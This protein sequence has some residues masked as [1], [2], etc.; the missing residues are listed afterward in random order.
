MQILQGYW[1]NVGINVDIKVV[2]TAVYFGLIFAR[3]KDATGQ[4]V[5]S[6]WPWGP[7]GPFPSF[8]NNVYHSANMFTS[9]GVHTTGNDPKADQ[10][11]QDAVHEPDETK[12]KQKWTDLMKYGYN[13]MWINMPIVEYPSYLVAGPNV[14]NFTRWAYTI[15]Q[16][17]YVGITHASK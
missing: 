5:G 14:G 6:I 3:A 8:F 9:V 1:K 4:V 7:T 12:S 15:L 16:Q 17:A 13:T 11:Y 2:D 10:M